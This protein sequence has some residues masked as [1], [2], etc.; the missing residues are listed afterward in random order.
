MSEYIVLQIEQQL[1]AL[2]APVVASQ[3]AIAL[4]DAMARNEY[5]YRVGCAGSR[6]SSCGSRLADGLGNLTVG[7]CAA[8]WDSS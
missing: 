6:D 8:K 3:L 5:G 2:H 1:L 7:A 4:Y